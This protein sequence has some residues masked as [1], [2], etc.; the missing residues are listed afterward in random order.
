MN[1]PVFWLPVPPLYTGILTA[2]THLKLDAGGTGTA[3]ALGV[4]TQEA[5]MG[6]VAIVLGTR[7]RDE[8]RRAFK[9]LHLHHVLQALAAGKM[10]V[11]QARRGWR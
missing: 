10:G 11:R 4:G 6:A 8:G 3:A 1:M 2:A 9:H 5:E 7:G